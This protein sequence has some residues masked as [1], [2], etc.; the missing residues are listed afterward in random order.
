MYLV[1]EAATA[2]TK[3]IA[4]LADHFLLLN[5]MG[6]SLRLFL[7]LLKLGLTLLHFLPPKY[8]LPFGV[9]IKLKLGE[10]CAVPK[11]IRC[12]ATSLLEPVASTR[13]AFQLNDDYFGS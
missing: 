12:Y 6:F 2:T 3:N 9:F 7:N 11:H 5:Y 4:Y 8:G 10:A 13:L 1:M